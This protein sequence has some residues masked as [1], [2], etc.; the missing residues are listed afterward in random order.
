MK[1]YYLNLI[2]FI[3]CILALL[4][5]SPQKDTLEFFI[6]GVLAVLNLFVF[7]KKKS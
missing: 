1:L 7:F 4:K 6:L 3:A 2:A 5:L